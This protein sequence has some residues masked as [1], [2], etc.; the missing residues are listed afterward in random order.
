MMLGDLSSGRDNNFN[1]IRFCAAFAVLVSHSFALA[2]GTPDAEPLYTTYGL[3]WGDIAVDVFFVT[4]GFLVT[5]S[6]LNRRSAVAFVKARVLRIF[7]A[8]WIML[9]ISVFGV[10]LAFTTWDAHAYLG[11]GATWRYLLKNALLFRGIEYRLPGLF[12][13]NPASLKVNGSLWTLKPEVQM[14]VLLLAL[15]LPLR[16][17]LPYAV[18]G[19]AAVAGIVYLVHRNFSDELFEFPRLAFMFF[20]GASAYAFRD[21]IPLSRSAF[22]GL[23]C[24]AVLSALNRAAFFFALS[25]TLPYLLLYAAYTFKGFILSFNRLGDYSYGIYIYAFLVQQTIAH[26][27]PGIS[28]AALMA[29][30]AAVTLTLAVLSWHLVEKQALALKSWRLARRAAVPA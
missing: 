15:W 1:L 2:V 23:L 28:I 14:Y 17:F 12:Q 25:L 29:S 5:A 20:T 27:V 18:A 8:L 6:L 3:T 24:V 4:S 19:V 10:G 13:S 9:A 7:P 22:G 16:K 26:M 30:S 21:R 11:A